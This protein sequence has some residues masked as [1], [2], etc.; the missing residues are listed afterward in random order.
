MSSVLIIGA[1]EHGHVVEETIQAMDVFSDVLFIDDYRP[2]AFGTTQDL[3]R[4]R[5]DFLYAFPGIGNN[6]YRELVFKK[7][8]SLDYSI[9]TLVHP[10]SFVSPSA[11]IDCGTIV[12]PGAIIHSRSTIGRA[13][14]VSIGALIDHDVTVGDYTHI[15]PGVLCLPGSNIKERAIIDEKRI[16][17]RGDDLY[18]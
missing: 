12:L 16:V 7:L 10:A 5:K 17:C 14:I 1:G 6:Q 4:L 13:C 15:K 18:V 2:E 11:T 8:L 9:P 3:E